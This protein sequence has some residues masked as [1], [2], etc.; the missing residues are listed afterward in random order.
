MYDS[1]SGAYSMEISTFSRGFMTVKN[2]PE[3]PPHIW[4]ITIPIAIIIKITNTTVE[5]FVFDGFIKILYLARRLN[6]SAN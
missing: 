3:I 5:S 4:E 2:V 6:R 1:L